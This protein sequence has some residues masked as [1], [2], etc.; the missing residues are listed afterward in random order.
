MTITRDRKTQLRRD[1]RSK[2]VAK[3][4]AALVMSGADAFAECVDAEERALVLEEA[5]FICMV[6][7]ALN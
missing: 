4:Q 1:V 3:L 2:A 7:G 6:I 5:K